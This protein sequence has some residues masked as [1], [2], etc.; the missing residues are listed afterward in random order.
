MHPPAAQTR[1]A[2]IEGR[3]CALLQPPLEARPAGPYRTYLTA[4]DKNA[5]SASIWDGLSVL[6]NVSGM[7]PLA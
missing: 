6:L 7:I 3:A 4:D 2:A 5:T 1:T